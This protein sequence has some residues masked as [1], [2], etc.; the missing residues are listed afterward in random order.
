MGK[1]ILPNAVQRQPNHIYYVDK[2]GSI[3]E[4]PMN[5][6]GRKKNKKSKKIKNLN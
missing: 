3:C 5:R 6:G 1:I 2:D 4:A